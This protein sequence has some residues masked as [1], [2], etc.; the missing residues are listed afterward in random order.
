VQHDIRVSKVEKNG[1]CS[2]SSAYKL[3]INELINVDHL[4]VERNRLSKPPIKSTQG[5][6]C[7]LFAVQKYIV[8]KSTFG[9]NM[10]SRSALP[11]ISIRNIGWV[12]LF[13]R[14]VMIR[15][16]TLESTDSAKQMLKLE[17]VHVDVVHGV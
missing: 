15:T 17:Y 5:K 14:R 13:S 9:Q 2:V 3:C 10:K 12:K 7:K 1:K 4:E 11:K 6:K 8:G 16:K